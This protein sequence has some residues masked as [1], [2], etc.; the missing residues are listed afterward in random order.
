MVVSI[1]RVH[2]R[3]SGVPLFPDGMD[4]PSTRGGCTQGT[5]PLKLTKHSGSTADGMSLQ[6]CQFAEK[7]HESSPWSKISIVRDYS[8]LFPPVRCRKPTLQVVLLNVDLQEKIWKTWLKLRPQDGAKSKCQF[9]LITNCW[10]ARVD[11]IHKHSADPL[12]RCGII[13]RLHILCH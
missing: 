2:L 7:V 10:R 5:D 6:G 13:N 1:G 11:L 4:G 9:N 3:S 8:E 12:F